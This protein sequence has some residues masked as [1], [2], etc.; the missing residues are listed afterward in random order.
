MCCLT[1]I[2]YYYL[3]LLSS[4]PKEKQQ[5]LFA[6]TA[7]VPS[8][9]LPPPCL[10]VTSA[11]V[12]PTIKSACADLQLAWL[13]G[14]GGWCAESVHDPG[15]CSSISLR[16]GQTRCWKQRGQWCHWAHTLTARASPQALSALSYYVRMQEEA[17][18]G[19]ASTHTHARTQLTIMR[20]QPTGTHLPR[21]EN[22]LSSR[23]IFMER[24]QDK[25]HEKEEENTT[26]ELLDFKR[27]LIKRIKT[28]E[29]NKIQEKALIIGQHN[30]DFGARWA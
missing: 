21:S 16:P 2:L 26:S 17:P 8:L 7:A 20:H 25:F 10:T 14:W 13:W 27:T 29:Y 1:C 28:K 9:I 30:L 24:D 19:D 12:N 15:E 23:D 6:A 3:Q 22:L 11:S 4:K 18:T 5:V